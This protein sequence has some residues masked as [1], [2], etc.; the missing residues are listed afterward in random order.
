MGL[1]FGSRPIRDSIIPT[2]HP[3]SF[4]Q[5]ARWDKIK[6]I[7]GVQTERFRAAEKVQATRYQAI[8]DSLIQAEMSIARSLSP[9]LLPTVNEYLSEYGSGRGSSMSHFYRRA[10][11]R[12]SST[13]GVP[14]PYGLPLQIERPG[15]THPGEP[16]WVSVRDPASV[17][18][19]TYNRELLLT[20]QKL[21]PAV[22]SSL[23]GEETQEIPA[24]AGGRGKCA[25]TK[26]ND[27]IYWS[28]D[29]W[30]HRAGAIGTVGVQ[31]TLAGATVD[32]LV[33]CVKE[34]REQRVAVERRVLA[35]YLKVSQWRVF[36]A[37]R[38]AEDW[39]ILIKRTFYFMHRWRWLN[40]IVTP[41]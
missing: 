41:L 31:T 28:S 35:A 5:T 25:G 16:C 36:H 34:L 27:H 4:R 17:P 30:G 24:G 33:A 2:L 18:P 22:V 7:M 19:P 37:W 26:P 29:E 12:G 9:D 11:S 21:P 23:W 14:K 6:S 3:P 32:G 8:Q 38:G 10:S 13:V 1:K 15:S 40:A 20:L 39:E